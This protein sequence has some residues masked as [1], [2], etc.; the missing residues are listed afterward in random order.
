MAKKSGSIF[1]LVITISFS[2]A[3]VLAQP[4]F[5]QDCVSLKRETRQ[6]MHWQWGSGR[7]N[8]KCEDCFDALYVYL[9]GTT[10]KREL[11]N[12]LLGMTVGVL[13]GGAGFSLDGIYGRTYKG[14]PEGAYEE[15]RNGQRHNSAVQDIYT[16]TESQCGGLDN[17]LE[18]FVMA[19]DVGCNL[20]AAKTN[21]R[22]QVD[23]NPESV[24]AAYLAYEN[25]KRQGPRGRTWSM[26]M[27]LLGQEHN[28]G[29]RVTYRSCYKKDRDAFF[30]MV[31]N[32][33][34]EKDGFVK[35]QRAREERL[36]RRKEERR[37]HR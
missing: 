9:W 12:H 34:I 36:E 20:E 16:R 3:T 35:A 1:C 7:E 30:N 17:F 24:A 31:R 6:N 27:L 32:V 22:W 15:I 23:N 33:L 11:F 29:A 2:L 26:F 5:A 25:Y 28:D 19:S 8:A 18:L 4:T 10:P 14:S 21:I 37:D 13:T